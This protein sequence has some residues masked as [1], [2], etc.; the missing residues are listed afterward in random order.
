MGEKH[1]EI[2]DR[3]GGGCLGAITVEIPRADGALTMTARL[4]VSSCNEVYLAAASEGGP[5]S[6]N[7][8]G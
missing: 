4:W 3:N 8:G 1:C 2:G 5:Y 7:F 6:E